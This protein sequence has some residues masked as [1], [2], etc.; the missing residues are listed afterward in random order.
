M[1]MKIS[2][3]PAGGQYL[4]ISLSLIFLFFVAIPV[5]AVT[6]PPPPAYNP[7]VIEPLNNPMNPAGQ[8]ELS[9][10]KLVG[11]IIGYVLGIV[12]SAALVIFIYGGFRWMTA[13]GKAEQVQSAQQI[14][15][16]AGLGVAV[17]FGSYIILSLV[18]KALPAHAAQ[19][20]VNLSNPLGTTSVSG[21]FGRFIKGFLGLTGT[22][23]LVMFIYGG[24]TWLTS[25]GSPDKIK[26]GKDIFLWSVVGLIII[27]SSYLMVDFVIKGLT[28]AGPQAV[29]Q[30]QAGETFDKCLLNAGEKQDT[31]VC[32]DA[33]ETAIK[34]CPQKKII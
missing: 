17:I 12:G 23:A 14:M 5:F 9:V 34:A 3:P 8:P 24:I 21:L 4:F 27:F 22:I 15:L 33:Y 10:P 1:N 7:N 20:T 32:D 19:P 29:C 13:S 28:A 26:K 25:A 30:K 11:S 16:W 31:K 2:N 18:F 6:T